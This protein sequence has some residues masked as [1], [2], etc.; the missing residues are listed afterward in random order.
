MDA[1]N[2]GKLTNFKNTGG[3]QIYGFDALKFFMALMIVAIHTKA[4]HDV[5]IIRQITQPFLNSAVPIFFILSSYFLFRKMDSK[6]YSWTIYWPFLKRL[7]ILYAFWF[8]A[9]LPLTVYEK[10]S[11][12]D[13]G[14]PY[15]LWYVIKDFLF[16]Y[17]FAGSWFLTALIV[18]TLIVFILKK[19]LKAT[20][21]ILLILALLTFLYVKLVALCPLWL[22]KPYLFIQTNIREVVELTPVTGFIWCCVGCVLASSDAMKIISSR[23]GKRNIMVVFIITYI[24]SVFLPNN[25]AFV[26]LPFLVLSIILL[27]YIIRLEPRGLYMKLRNLSI[28]IYLLHFR[29]LYL[30]IIMPANCLHIL[31]YV[32]VVFSSLLIAELILKLEKVNSF[33]FLKYSH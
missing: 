18:G 22:Q 32:A 12:I 15:I 23:F 30:R 9:T 27:A 10:W 21:L 14:F 20:S 1:T 4:F 33:S 11:Y 25:T 7:F 19:C 13:Y 24:A 29:L 16:S 26:V 3:G 8:I 5:D 28:L 2:T 31:Y 17:T 6:G